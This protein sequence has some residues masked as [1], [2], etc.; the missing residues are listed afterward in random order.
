MNRQHVFLFF[1]K[2]SASVRR[3]QFR[4]LLIS[5]LILIEVAFDLFIPISLQL[6]IDQAIIPKQFDFLWFILAALSAGFVLS[7][8]ASIWRSYVSAAIVSGF[9]NDIRMVMFNHL[10]RLSMRFYSHTDTGELMSRFTNDL[11][12]VEEAAVQ[13]LKTFIFMLQNI[14][15]CVF[16]LFYLEWH[17]AL[18]MLILLPF[19]AVATHFVAPKA[20]DANYQK[21]QHE[22]NVASNIQENI[23]THKIIVSLNIQHNQFLKLKKQLSV[24]YA[25]N[26]SAHTLNIITQYI[27]ILSANFILVVLIGTGSF[28]VIQGFLSPGGFIG[29]LGVLM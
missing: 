20:A 2:M 4:L 23:S 3:Y 21:K 14:V 16:L 9:M 13:L 19:S 7:S 29:F 8:F 5:G 12:S 6:I 26:L 28:L 17:L 24:L 11:K 22:A 27:S 18:L 15:I 10:Q 25:K 1:K